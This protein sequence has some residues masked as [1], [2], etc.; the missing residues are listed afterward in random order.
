MK[1]SL[2]DALS[3]GVRLLQARNAREAKRLAD[4]LV[5]Q[6]PQSTPVRLFAA[7]AASLAGDVTA[8]IAHLDALPAAA[9]RSAVVALKKAR[10]LFADGRRADALR[11]AREAANRVEGKLE[12]LRMLAS[13]L[14]DC[15]QLEEAHHWLEEALKMAPGDVDGRGTVPP[16]PVAPRRRPDA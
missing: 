9:S 6:F 16:H 2:Q 1:G 7:D 8:A 14:R 12:L 15:Q 13:I 4:V 3:Q 5:P 10:L 11:L